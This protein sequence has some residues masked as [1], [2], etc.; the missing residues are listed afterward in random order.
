MHTSQV[1]TIKITQLLVS[2]LTLSISS[3]LLAGPKLFVN[4]I[5]IFKVSCAIG[6]KRGL[7]QQQ[8][9]ILTG[10]LLL[11]VNL[12]D[13]VYICRSIEWILCMQQFHKAGVDQTSTTNALLPYTSPLS[14][15]S[16]LC[17]SISY[18]LSVCSTFI[19]VSNI[20]LLLCVEQLSA[21][22]P[23]NGKSE[24]WSEESQKMILLMLC[25]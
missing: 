25:Y 3:K 4:I 7:H 5:R 20:I 12:Q 22:D 16:D 17:Y 13:F 15:A 1:Q 9:Q 24:H 19:I 21:S 23:Q 11:L 6:F 18:T 10:I 14:A 8:K 2:V